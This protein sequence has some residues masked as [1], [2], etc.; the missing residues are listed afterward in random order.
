MK[1]TVIRTAEFLNCNLNDDELTKLVH[2]LSFEQMRGNAMVN[3]QEGIDILRER[4]GNI[5][6]NRSPTKKSIIFGATTSRRNSKN[7]RIRNN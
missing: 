2:H 7:R 3:H 1:S 4:K 5:F 6:L